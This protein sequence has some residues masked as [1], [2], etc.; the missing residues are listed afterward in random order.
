[1]TR[2]VV[3]NNR[4][5]VTTMRGAT[6]GDDESDDEGVTGRDGV[7]VNLNRELGTGGN[8]SLFVFSPPYPF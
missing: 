7:G 2:R 6:G 3:C 5:G 4:L 1:M 8:I